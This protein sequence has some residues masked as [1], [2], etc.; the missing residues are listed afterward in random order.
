MN[1][2][3]AEITMKLRKRDGAVTDIDQ[4]GQIMSARID[5]LRIER[6]A[7]FDSFVAKV[8][9]FTP[10]VILVDIQVKLRLPP[11]AKSSKTLVNRLSRLQSK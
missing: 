10:E 2:V 1:S 8:V 5:A 3:G 4:A 11:W 6:Y 9:K 7:A